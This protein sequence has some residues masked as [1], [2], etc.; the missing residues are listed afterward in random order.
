MKGGELVNSI[1]EIAFINNNFKSDTK[2]KSKDSK[3]NSFE[4]ILNGKLNNKKNKADDGKNEVQNGQTISLANKNYS[5]CKN[6]EDSKV[7][8]KRKDIDCKKTQ[9]DEVV[10]ND[11]KEN[12]K[13]IIAYINK[14]LLNNEE[15][16][17]N[18]DLKSLLIQFEN[19]E[20]HV[21]GENIIEL[22]NQ[23]KNLLQTYEKNKGIKMEQDIDKIISKLDLL[24]EDLLNENKQNG[25]FNFSQ[26]FLSEI[27]NMKENN[28]YIKSDANKENKEIRLVNKEKQEDHKIP[29]KESLLIEDKKVIEN[30]FIGN[31]SEKILIINNHMNSLIDRFNGVKENILNNY[32]DKLVNEKTLFHNIDKN[33]LMKQIVEKLIINPR[34]MNPEIRIKLKPE[35]LGD[36]FLKITTKENLVSARIIVENYQVKQA[37]EANLDMLKDNLKEQGLEVYEFSI[38]IGQ[39]SNFDNYNS[40]SGYNRNYSMNQEKN[41]LIS[42]EI[43]NEFLYENGLLDSFIENNIDLKA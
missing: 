26:N 7:K 24:V 37:I 23:I 43:E 27:G 4:N 16:E 18:S 3:H 14:I 9:K 33:M 32:E 31:K 6:D 2:C 35:V 13:E 29:I 30:D 20:K 36:L 22:T 42:Q 25:N 8:L 17:L 19:D 38:D 21:L 10:Y 5:K 12:I 28:M 11:E 40:Q 34:K 1:A 41:K 39:S 15:L